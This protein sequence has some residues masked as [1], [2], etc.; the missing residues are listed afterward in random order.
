MEEGKLQYP[1]HITKATL[2]DN[3]GF[4]GDTMFSKDDS[5]DQ[6]FFCPAESDEQS[7]Q[8]EKY[9]E[10]IKTTPRRILK[11]FGDKKASKNCLFRKTFEKEEALRC[12]SDA[13][14]VIHIVEKMNLGEEQ[15][16][17]CG[18]NKN[19]ILYEFVYEVSI[20]VF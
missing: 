9:N 6:V 2:D 15:I 5:N 19:S 1:N 4:T 14:P 11:H 8:I 7:K 10:L 12:V 13:T 20:A 17:F 16:R 18:P 3:Q